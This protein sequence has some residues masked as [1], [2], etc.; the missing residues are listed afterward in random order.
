MTEAE[1]LR[2]ELKQLK[3]REA[4]IKKKL[5]ELEAVKPTL[6]INVVSIYLKGGETELVKALDGLE[7]EELKVV[8]KS[9][10]LDLCRVMY[11]VKSK[12]KLIDFILDMAK[13]R[14]TAGDVFRNYQY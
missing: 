9:N 10:A 13:R 1:K 11:R 4:E 8:I 2:A 12:D 5:K 3:A 6:D 14:A 7:V